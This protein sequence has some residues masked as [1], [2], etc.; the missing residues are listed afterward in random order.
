MFTHKNNFQADHAN[1]TK[2]FV[3]LLIVYYFNSL[4]PLKQSLQG[5]HFPI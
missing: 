5:K 1:Y 4:D 2:T 3:R